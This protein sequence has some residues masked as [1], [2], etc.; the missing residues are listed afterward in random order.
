MLAK[1]DF[2][3]LASKFA[4]DFIVVFLGS[5]AVLGIQGEGI[6][7]PKALGAA[8]VSAVSVALF[9]AVRDLNLPFVNLGKP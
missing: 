4:R 5:Q 3:R 7:D 2:N 1:I 6:F 8:A 9:R